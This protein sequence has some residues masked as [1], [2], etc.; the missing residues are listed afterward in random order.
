MGSYVFSK[1]YIHRMWIENH[2][3]L[4]KNH[5]ERDLLSDECAN[6]RHVVIKFDLIGIIEID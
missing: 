6:N 2:V 1:E 3:N 5:L 4:S